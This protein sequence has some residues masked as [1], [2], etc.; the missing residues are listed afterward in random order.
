MKS[1]HLLVEKHKYQ[2]FILASLILAA[3]F[4]NSVSHF[5]TLQLNLSMKMQY[6]MYVKRWY[7]DELEQRNECEKVALG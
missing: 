2:Y 3:C 5:S 1:L 6:V 7:C 4:I